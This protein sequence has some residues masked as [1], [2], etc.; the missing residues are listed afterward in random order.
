MA[1][2]EPFIQAPGEFIETLRV[3]GQTVPA[4]RGTL[5]NSMSDLIVQKRVDL[6]AVRLQLLDGGHHELLDALNRL[7]DLI[8][9]YIEEDG[10]EE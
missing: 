6:A 9:P 4:Q 10:V 1:C 7:V 5:A 2:M 8:E 3:Y